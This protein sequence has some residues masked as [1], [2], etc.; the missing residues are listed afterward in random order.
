M[1]MLVHVRGYFL[2][3][4]TAVKCFVEEEIGQTFTPVTSVGLWWWLC[5][6]TWVVEWVWCAVCG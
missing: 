2:A 3:A 4:G 6:Y 5:R 1:V